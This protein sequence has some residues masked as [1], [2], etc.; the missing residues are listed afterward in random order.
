MKTPAHLKYIQFNVQTNTIP[1]SKVSLSNLKYS[2]ERTPKLVFRAA[3]S[4]Y[5]LMREG[6]NIIL[7]D[8]Y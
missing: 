2:P 5:L 4:M 3:K 6:G 7:S 1:I 8:W